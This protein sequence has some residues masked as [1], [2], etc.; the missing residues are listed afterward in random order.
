[1]IRIGVFA[2]IGQVSID[3]LRHYDRVG[4]LKPTQVDDA[5]GY[6]LYTI[7]QLPRL[8]RILAF[9]DMGL[10]LEQIAALLDG[11]VS[12]DE[13]RG[14]LRLRQ[15]QLREL[16]DAT[17]AQ[18]AQLDARL[19]ELERENEM[20][21]YEVLLKTIEPAL[22]AGRRFILKENKGESLEDLGLAFDETRDYVQARNAQAGPPIAVWYTPINQEVDHDVEAAFPVTTAIDASE[23]IQVHTL[24]AE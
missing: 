17:S 13:M 21:T 24:P 15:A 18:L 6:R 14:M 10:P 2:R 22:V 4:L 23:H 5:T 20:S 8:H 12:A 9:K 16:L 11:G 1:M 3:A 19:I 7:E